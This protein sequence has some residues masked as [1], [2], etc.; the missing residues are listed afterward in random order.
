[1]E[2]FGMEVGAIAMNYDEDGTPRLLVR[3]WPPPEIVEITVTA[4]R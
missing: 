2:M 4:R 3:L 1:M